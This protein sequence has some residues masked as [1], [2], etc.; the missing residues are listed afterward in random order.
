MSGT[1]GSSLAMVSWPPALEVAGSRREM[2]LD[3][4]AA[5]S[6]GHAAAGLKHGDNIKLRTIH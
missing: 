4:A 6:L 5:G 3:M 1:E 2:G